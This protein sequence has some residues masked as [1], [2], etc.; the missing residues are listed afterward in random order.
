[1]KRYSLS[2]KR[3]VCRGH[4]PVIDRPVELQSIFLPDT[5][6]AA[7]KLRGIIPDAAIDEATGAPFISPR[8]LRP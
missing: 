2:F 6:S 7:G 1:M 8:G 4:D 5:I 3:I